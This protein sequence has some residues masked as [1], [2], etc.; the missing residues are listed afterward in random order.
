MQEDNQLA[1][2]LMTEVELIAYL[3]IPEVSKSKDYHNVIA[4]LKRVY[5]LPCIH[6]CRQPLSLTLSYYSSSCL[7]VCE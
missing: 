5:D 7:L 6:I 2:E 3:R 4:H 1:S